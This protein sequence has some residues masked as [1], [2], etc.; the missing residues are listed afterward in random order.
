VTVAGRFQSARGTS[1]L[2]HAVQWWGL[3]CL[4]SGA[5]VRARRSRKRTK[6][7]VR[8]TRKRRRRAACNRTARAAAEAEV[9]ARAERLR[10]VVVVGVFPLTRASREGTG[11]NSGAAEEVTA[12]GLQ[13]CGRPVRG[14]QRCDRQRFVPQESGVHV[15]RATGNQPCRSVSAALTFAAPSRTGERPLVG[16]WRGI[17]SSRDTRR[18]SSWN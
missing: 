3:Q 15:G 10:D 18:S 8:A 1:R 17:R 16:L 12:F 11:R 14:H 13:Q 9:C 5:C 7:R 4:G 6:R 2:S